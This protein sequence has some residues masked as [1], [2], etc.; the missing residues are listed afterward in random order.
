MMKLSDCPKEHGR[1][2]FWEK[3]VGDTDDV[4]IFGIAQ[5]VTLGGVQVLDG[6]T[7][8]CDAN[9]RKGPHGFHSWTG[10]Q[11]SCGS[12]EPP[13]PLTGHHYAA[14][15]KITAIFPVIEAL[16]YGHIMYF[17]MVDPEDEVKTIQEQHTDSSRT[18]QEV[19]R[20]LLEWDYAYTE[21]GNRERIAEVSHGMVEVLQIP[22]SIKTWLLTELPMEKVSRFL[23][24]VENAQE[25]ADVSEIP[26]LSDEFSEWLYDKI[27]T[28]RSIGEYDADRSDA[29][30]G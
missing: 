17:E 23:S 12:T 22:E 1:I 7:I 27:S 28:T 8:R 29:T 6:E 18:L 5:H 20:L 4:G 19:F 13:Y 21:L 25:R 2:G 26:P 16:P 10:S 15:G 9:S 14:F 30:G 24:G 3:I 11:C